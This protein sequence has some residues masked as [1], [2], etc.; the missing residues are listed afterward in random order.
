MPTALLTLAL[1]LKFNMSILMPNSSSPVGRYYMPKT[2]PLK[3]LGLECWTADL[4]GKFIAEQV[5]KSKRILTAQRQAEMKDFLL[6]PNRISQDLD[7]IARQK[8][9]NDKAW[10]LKHFELQSSQ[11]YRHAEVVKGC[12][13]NARYAACYNNAFEMICKSHRRLAHA[14]KSLQ[15]YMYFANNSIR[16]RPTH[17][18]ICNVWYRIS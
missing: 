7:P 4:A 3:P 6:Y 11:I 9:A 12:Q 14:C 17:D 13:A 18:E 16:V 5:L 15:F 2:L 8:F 1:S 10:T